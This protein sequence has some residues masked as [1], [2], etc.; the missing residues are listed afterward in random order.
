MDELKALWPLGKFP[1]LV[2]DG[3][4]VAETSCIIE[5]LQAR[6]P[7]PNVWIPEGEAGRRVRFL[8]RFFDLHIQGNMQPTVNHAI[9]PDGE[10][11]AAQRG[12]RRAADRLRLAGGEF[13]RRRVGGGRQLHAGRLRRRPGPVLRRL[14]RR[15]RRRAAAPRR[16]IAR[17]CWR[18]RR[19]RKSVE[20]ARPYRAL[21]PARSAR[22][23]LIDSACDIVTSALSM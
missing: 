3:E 11:L 13:A 21:F 9:W 23:R 12:D 7:G 1:I 15:D 6:H 14:G 16:P 2:D 20:G 22:P 18:I 5:H 17:G 8:D 19:W 4:V 10:G